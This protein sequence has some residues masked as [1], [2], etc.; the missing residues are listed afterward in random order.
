MW[1]G[2]FSSP[3][4]QLATHMFCLNVAFLKMLV[5]LGEPRWGCAVGQGHLRSLTLP[6]TARGR[7]AAGTQLQ[8]F[9]TW[10]GFQW[11]FRQ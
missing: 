2:F 4:P 5:L 6:D 1:W 9:S 3:P 7:S 8:I 11:V 10:L